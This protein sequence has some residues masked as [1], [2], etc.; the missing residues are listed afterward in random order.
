M[1]YRKHAA[2]GYMVRTQVKI[3]TQDKGTAIRASRI[4]ASKIAEAKR[5]VR[6]GAAA[7]CSIGDRMD[8]FLSDFAAGLGKRRRGYETL[9]RH[10]RRLE[11]FNK[12]FQRKPI[13]AIERKQVE[14]WIKRRLKAGVSADTVKIDLTSLYAFAR[15]ARK[16]EYATA[17]LPLLEVER[18]FTDGKMPGTNQKLPN[19]LEPDEL[20][21]IIK[22]IKEERLDMGL[23]LNGM[24]F[25]GRRPAAIAVVRREDVRLPQGKEA[26]RIR[27]PP[28]KGGREEV[29]RIPPGTKREEWVRSCLS[30][31]EEF[32]Q[33]A[34]HCPL[35]PCAGSRSR[36]RPGGWTTQ[37]F[38]MALARLLKSLRIDMTAYVV[39]H[40]CATFLHDRPGS[41]LASTQKFLS[42]NTIR[43]Q[44]AYSHH[45]NAPAEKAFRLIEDEFGDL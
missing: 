11:M 43:Q 4:L 7:C 41:T 5:L 14:R 39:R 6:E 3:I 35:V 26:G 24:V 2:G 15:W 1:A 21:D 10:K 30:L 34:P 18:L 31:G 9:K 44:D 19:V 20:K 37:S 8:E 23:F 22:K 38:G 17:R 40:S 33:D 42:H 32:G 25:W 27:F 13:D 45:T 28:L 12:T 29:F 16:K 36:V